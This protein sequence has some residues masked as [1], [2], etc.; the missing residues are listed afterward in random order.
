MEDIE[1]I[2]N[3]Y[4]SGFPIEMVFL[5]DVIG[6]LY[7]GEANQGKMFRVFSGISVLI[8]CFGIL[9]LSTY[10]AV[11]RK[12]EIGIR[13]VLGA[14]T[15]QLSILLTKDLVALV[16]LANMLAAP[17]AYLILKKWSE[18]FA[19]R[20][21]FEPL[22][23]LLAALLVTAIALVIVSVNAARAANEDPVKALRPE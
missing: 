5:D 2:W 11:Q 4:E 6:R 7:A 17:L 21:T 12:K 19:Y 9:G 22:I 16:L 18:N 20:A 23:F 15:S 8:A 3:S 13:K 14:S 10:I 1:K